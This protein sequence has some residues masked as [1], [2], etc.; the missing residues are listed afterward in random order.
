M[1]KWISSDVASI[2]ETKFSVDLNV[3]EVELE[4]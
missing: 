4:G 2:W 1:T 3:G